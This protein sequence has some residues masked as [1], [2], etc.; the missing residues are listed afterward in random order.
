MPA[1]KT[2]DV[3][4]GFLVAGGLMSSCVG[5]ISQAVPAAMSQIVR[6]HIR[7]RLYKALP[8]SVLQLSRSPPIT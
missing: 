4:W 3:S 5:V 1:V 8:C 6:Q 7:T 2:C